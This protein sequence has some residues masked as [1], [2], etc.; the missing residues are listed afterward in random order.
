MTE[1]LLIPYGCPF[2]FAPFFGGPTGRV[3]DH[4]TGEIPF[5]LLRIFGGMGVVYK[6]HDTVLNRPSAIKFLHSPFNDSLH[7]KRSRS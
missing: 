1:I 4:E 3:R 2:R 5:M 6:T 7:I